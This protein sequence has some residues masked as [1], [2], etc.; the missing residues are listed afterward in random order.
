MLGS[1]RQPENTKKG[2]DVSRTSS[3]PQSP[4]MARQAERA[5]MTGLSPIEEMRLAQNELRAK[6]AARLPPLS[7]KQGPPLPPKQGQ[8]APTRRMTLHDQLTQSTL[9]QLVTMRNMIRKIKNRTKVAVVQ[10]ADGKISEFQDQ[11]LERDMDE[12][13]PGALKNFIWGNTDAPDKVVVQLRHWILLRP[14]PRTSSLST[15]RKRKSTSCQCPRTSFHPTASFECVG[16]S[17]PLR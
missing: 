6:A 1:K 15:R 13:T 5:H 14:Y 2:P 4:F 11:R 17:F 8:T 9:T 16:I 12:L 7:P 10:P 3:M